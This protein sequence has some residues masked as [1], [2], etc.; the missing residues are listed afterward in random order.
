MACGQL[1]GSL[2]NSGVFR[3]KQACFSYDGRI[4]L[5]ALAFTALVVTS[6]FWGQQPASAQT[7]ACAIVQITTTT[8]ENVPGYSVPPAISADGTHIAFLSSA[9]IVNNENPDLNQELFIYDA[10][11]S[12]TK[13]ITH[14]VAPE[15]VHQQFSITIGGE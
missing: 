11:S 13:Q 5:P 4:S 12:T 3:N 2:Q 9:N 6:A 7:Q 14:T 10:N 15:V 8:G 1:T